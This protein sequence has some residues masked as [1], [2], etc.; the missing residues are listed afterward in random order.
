MVNF[1]I[2]IDDSGAVRVDDEYEIGRLDTLKEVPVEFL[3]DILV[4]QDWLPVCGV[5]IF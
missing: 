3:E 2:T 4:S 1:Q 5:V